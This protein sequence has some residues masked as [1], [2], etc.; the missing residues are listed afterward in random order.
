MVEP[1][2]DYGHWRWWQ[3]WMAVFGGQDGAIREV[4]LAATTMDDALAEAQ[5]LTGDDEQLVAVTDALGGG[6]FQVDDEDDQS[7]RSPLWTTTWPTWNV[8]EVPSPPPNGSRPGPGVTS[9]GVHI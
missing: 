7:P 6:I 5:T 9:V 8:N 4:E 2:H 3:E 1:E